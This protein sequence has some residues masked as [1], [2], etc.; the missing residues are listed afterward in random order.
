MTLCTAGRASINS[1]QRFMFGQLLTS[2]PK[3]LN[4]HGI[5]KGKYEMSA[6]VGR[7]GKAMYVCPGE[8]NRTSNMSH[9]F[10]VFE[11]SLHAVSQSGNG[12]PVRHLTLHMSWA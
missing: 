3:K 6:R 2:T 12:A 10:N 9:A 11:C 4:I 7:S 8:A 5:E 1:P